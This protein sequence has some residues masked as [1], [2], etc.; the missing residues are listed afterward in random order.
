MD[1]NTALNVACDFDGY[2]VCQMPADTVE[3]ELKIKTTR[4]KYT[5]HKDTCMRTERYCPWDRV[6]KRSK[7]HTRR[8][9]TRREVDSEIITSNSE[10]NLQTG[11]GFTY[12]PEIYTNL[13][14]AKTITLTDT[15]NDNVEITNPNFIGEFCKE[16]LKKY[17]RCWCY[18]SDWE[19]DLIDVE[20]P[21][22]PTQSNDPQNLTMTVLPKRQPPPGWVEFG[23]QV[24][25]NNAKDE[26]KDNKPIDKIIIKG[27]RSITMKEFKEI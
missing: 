20:A 1:H 3:M 6:D 14:F 24:T 15:N 25:K 12:S 19:E 18:K 27:I 9:T 8:R 10:T 2:L 17:N 5:L 26:F 22:T 11:K 13:E 4:G 23:K 21:K 16:C 7:I